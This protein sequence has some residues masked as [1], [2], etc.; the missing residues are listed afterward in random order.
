MTIVIQDAL[1]PYELQSIQLSRLVANHRDVLSK[2]VTQH[3]VQK[4]AYWE[5]KTVI[6][7]DIAGGELGPGAASK[8]QRR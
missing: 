5:Q 1:H 3:R 4:S 6:K 7:P 2:K 8:K